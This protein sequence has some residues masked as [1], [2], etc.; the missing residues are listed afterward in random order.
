MPLPWAAGLWD[1]IDLGGR[2]RSPLREAS[3]HVPP[4]FTVIIPT[5]GDSPFLRAALRSALQDDVDLELL[6]VHDRA[7]GVDRS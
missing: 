6:L 3:P 1:R 7:I 5:R 2:S 4:E